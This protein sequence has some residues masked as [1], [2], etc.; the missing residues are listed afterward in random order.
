MKILVQELELQIFGRVQGVNF[1]NLIKSKADGL[2]LKGL[3][4]NKPDGSIFLVVQGSE[5]A[6]KEFLAWLQQNPGLSKVSAMHYYW[7]SPSKDFENFQVIKTKSFLADQMTSMYQ[8]G[9]SFLKT[10]TKIPEH[11]AIIPDGNRRWAARQGLQAAW[12]HYS[13]ASFQHLFDLLHEARHL[14]VRFLTFWGFSTENWKRDQKEIQALFD[15]LL[16]SVDALRNE[17]HTHHIHFRHLGRKDRLPQPLIEA[18]ERLE[19]ETRSYNALHVQLCLDY[20]GRDELLRAVNI[21]LEKKIKNV[22]E[23]ML[24]ATLDSK[25]IP[26][27]DLIIRTSGEQRLSGFM[28]FQSTYAELYFSPVH[29]PDFDAAAFRKAVLSYGQRERRFGGNA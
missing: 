4:M 28:P 11:V 10:K 16:R 9:K 8:L 17:A 24:S 6:L 3:V 22:D 14:G 19:E 5:K 21:L 15:L 25:D 1:R 18:L 26:D 23:K 29:F 20:G 7:R 12:G 13:S 27:V 2:E